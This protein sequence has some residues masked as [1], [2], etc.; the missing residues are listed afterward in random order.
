MANEWNY[1]DVW[2]AAAAGFPSAP[3]LI[4]GEHIVSWHEF[5][6]RATGVANSLLSAGLTHDSKVAQYLRNGPEFLESFFASIKVGLVPVN[7][8]FRYSDDELVH[9]WD[10][11][12]AEAVV[13]ESDFTEAVARVKSRLP[14]VRIW[15]RVGGRDDGPDWAVPYDDAAAAGSYE[16]P[17]WPRTGG[18]LVLLYTGG[19]TGKPKGVMWRQHDLFR[20]LEA[21]RGTELQEQADPIRFVTEQKA[22]TCLPAAPMIHG[23]ACW[24]VLPI[25]ARGGSV[26]TLTQPSLDPVE[27]LDALVARDVTGLCVVGEAFVRPLL[28][29]L[30]AASGRWDLSRLRVLFSSGAA[31]SERSKTEFLRHAP[32][33]TV[34]D[35]IGSSE[36]GSL[37]RSVTSNAVATTTTTTF[38]LSASTRVIDENGIDVVPGSGQ[39]GRLAISGFLP[40]GYYRDPVKTAE[41]FLELDGRR[42]VV[43]GDWAEVTEDGSI[44]LLGRGSSCI[45]TGGE[46][47]YPEEVEDVLMEAPQVDDAGV[48]G[49]PDQRLGERIVAVVRLNADYVD[50]EEE[51]LVAFVKS[52]L[53]GY[54]APKSIVFV[55]ALP[56]GPNGK[57]DHGALKTMAAK[58]AR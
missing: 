21:S 1:A 38:Q 32:N 18:D 54:K 45:N 6:T 28:R 23:T 19:T 15:I 39:S 10:D 11:C 40:L 46:K 14:K 13:F 58:A 42:Y 5:N 47:V 36:S 44:R 9:L 55:E 22:L 48:V 41:T 24:F 25:L 3:A 43:A 34:V 33:A 26:V 17:S 4:H 20:M 7:T 57:L 12:E 8:N 27:L 35:G 30:A 29:E 2:E 52:R 51:T 49:I 16:A 50:V 37:A 53:A 56:R 31:L